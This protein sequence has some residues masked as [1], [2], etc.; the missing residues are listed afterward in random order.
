MK[1]FDNKNL[2]Q[3]RRAAPEGMYSQ[4]RERIVLERIKMAQTRR[5]L[6]VGS[7]LLLI[8]GVINIS[9][10]LFYKNEQPQA[11]TQNTEKMLYETY[12]DNQIPFSQ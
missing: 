1:N 11:D 12:F 10:I 6:A 5:Q 3:S 2:K 4:V 9:I 7:A 8:V